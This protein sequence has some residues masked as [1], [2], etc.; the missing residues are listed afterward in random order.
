MCKKILLACGQLGLGVNLL[1]FINFLWKHITII[2]HANVISHWLEHQFDYCICNVAYICH[3]LT[4][5]VMG[6]IFILILWYSFQLCCLFVCFVCC[7]HSRLKKEGKKRHKPKILK[8]ESKCHAF[9]SA[10]RHIPQTIKIHVIT[11]F[12]SLRRPGTDL[13]LHGIN[14]TWSP[15]C[16]SMFP[17]ILWAVGV[18]LNCCITCNVTEFP[19]R[20]P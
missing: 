19:P 6:K 13:S 18:H 16:Y 10:L 11:I 3:T 14:T 8:K 5:I 2:N 17:V 9:I 20:F 7:W 1:L 15:T 4:H 12:Y